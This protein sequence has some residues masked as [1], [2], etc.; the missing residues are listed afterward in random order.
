MFKQAGI[1]MFNSD[2]NP[3][4]WLRTYSTTVCVASGNNDIMVAYFPMIMSR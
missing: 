3:K 1:D 2:S 4:T